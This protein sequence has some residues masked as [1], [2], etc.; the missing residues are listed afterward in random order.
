[1]EYTDESGSRPE[2]LRVESKL[3]N[4]LSGTSKQ[5]IIKSLLIAVKDWIQLFWNRKNDMEVRRI[6][7]VFLPGIDPFFLWY[8]L[9]VGTAAVSA[10]I[11]VNADRTAVFANARVDTKVSGLA[12]SNCIDD[13][14]LILRWC[15]FLTIVIIEAVE[16]ILNSKIVHYSAPPSSIVSRGL[17]TPISD[18]LLMCR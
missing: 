5:Q 4:S 6:Q 16:H 3:F 14:Y 12:V 17:L 8:L 18:L 11:V 1:M 9:T 10:R 7:N 15:V 13:L 2:K